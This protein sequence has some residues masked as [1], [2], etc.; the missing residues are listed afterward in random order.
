MAK[1]LY[2]KENDNVEN[3]VLK[4][5]FPTDTMHE[6]KKNYIA[7][8]QRKYCDF[9]LEQL[10]KTF[11]AVSRGS[12]ALLKE[13]LLMK[14]PSIVYGAENVWEAM[15]VVSQAEAMLCISLHVQIGIFIYLKPHVTWCKDTRSI[16]RVRAKV[17]YGK[18][19][20]NCDKK[21]IALLLKIE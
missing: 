9:S 6:A 21:P 10:A 19:V 13:A 12:K 18:T 16:K 11:N 14:E 3:E 5:L 7:V 8:Q 1:E 20:K 15:A 2:R 4:E 17:V